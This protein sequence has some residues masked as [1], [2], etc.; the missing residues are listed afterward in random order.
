MSELRPDDRDLDLERELRALSR[1]LDAFRVGAPP[2]ALIEAIYDEARRRGL[3]RVHWLT[4][5]SNHAA[6][7][8]YDKLAS[9]DGFVQYR[10]K[11]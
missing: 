7:K 10:R 5:E 8:L 3:A 9:Y 4:K 11:I 6:R 1:E 2:R